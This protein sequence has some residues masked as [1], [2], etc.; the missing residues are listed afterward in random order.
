MV[1][2]L[3][4]SYFKWQE[5]NGGLKWAKACQ[6]YGPEG[7]SLITIN[8]T[9]IDVCGSN[10]AKLTVCTNFNW[11]SGICNLK[12]FDSTADFPA[13]SFTGSICGW[14]NRSEPSRKNDGEKKICNS[15]IK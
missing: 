1:L 7:S 13:Y 12:H 2:S 15:C 4:K 11:Q 6:F 10:C 14:V 9:T 5:D 8:S 3:E